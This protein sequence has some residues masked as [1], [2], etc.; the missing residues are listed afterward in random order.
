MPE[1]R[2]GIQSPDGGL[3]RDMCPPKDLGSHMKLPNGQRL[4]GNCPKR[5]LRA[6]LHTG[7]SHNS[8][9]PQGHNRIEKEG[10]DEGN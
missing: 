9:S 6:G 10:K 4:G 8:L 1:G 7:E 3:R 5:P 2:L